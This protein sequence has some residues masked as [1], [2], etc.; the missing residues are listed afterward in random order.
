MLTKKKLAS[1]AMAGVMTLSLAA[2]AFAASSSESTTNRS[3]KVTAAYQAVTINVVVP[4]TGTVVINPYGL[5]VEIGKDES[6][7]KIEISNQ[8]IV[9]KPMAI[10]NQAGLDLDMNVT[11]T[12][13]LTGTLK[14]SADAAKDSTA[15]Q[16]KVTLY[17]APTTTLTGDKDTVTDAKIA[18]FYKTTYEDSQGWAGVTDVKAIDLASGTN[19]TDGQK[20]VVLK[21]AKT[22]DDTGAFSEYEAGSI[23][24]IAFDGVCATEPKTAWTTKDGLTCTLAF[25]FTPHVAETTTD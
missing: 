23:A 5:P 25:T 15:N 3:L 4:T 6:D 11:T 10:K 1:L 13:A 14:L 24:L 18:A 22:E 21:A 17:I 7:K 16:A 12:T 20:A 9:A 2:P 19:A 8:Q